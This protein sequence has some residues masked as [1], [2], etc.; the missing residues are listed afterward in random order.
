MGAF[1]QKPWRTAHK[2]FLRPRCAGLP[3]RRR[4]QCPAA[5]GRHGAG[6]PLRLLKGKFC[7][8]ILLRADP[9]HLPPIVDVG[10][11]SGFNRPFR[12]GFLWGNPITWAN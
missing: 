12:F 2:H 5:Y 7:K 11:V 3:F 8:V 1:K 6:E 4:L 9:I 10:S